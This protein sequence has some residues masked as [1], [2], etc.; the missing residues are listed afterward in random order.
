MFVDPF[1]LI[2]QGEGDGVDEGDYGHITQGVEI[3]PDE[4]APSEQDKVGEP[5]Q[6]TTNPD[7]YHIYSDGRIEKEVTSE[8]V[9]RYIYHSSNGNEK[10]LGE[11]QIM[12]NNLVLM[13]NS[14]SFYNSTFKDNYHGYLSRDDAT[15]FVASSYSFFEAMGIRV[16]VTQFTDEKGHHSGSPKFFGNAF[17]VKY[18]S[19]LGNSESPNTAVWTSGSN[20][21]KVNSQIMLNTFIK[22]GYNN[23]YSAITENATGTGSELEGSKYVNGEGR[24]HHKHHIHFQNYNK[25]HISTFRTK[26]DS[27]S[28]SYEPSST[29]PFSTGVH[30]NIININIR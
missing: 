18:I 4:K 24:W 13:P 25:S 12:S 19:K 21:D 11:Y 26:F 29:L 17:D 3:N 27:P 30:I 23:Q 28:I 20:Y 1:G 8:S 9:D 16:T 10:I 2:A 22:F 14:T 5:G 6:T 15:A 7:N